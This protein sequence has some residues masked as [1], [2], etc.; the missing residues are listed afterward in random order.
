[1]SEKVAIVV[2]SLG[3]F[4]SGFILAYV[5][6]WRLA[7]AITSI[8][9]CIMVLNFLFLF[10]SSLKYT[11]EGGSLAEEAISTVRTAQAFGTQI[12][13]SGL[14]DLCVAK[15][16]NVEMKSALASDLYSLSSIPPFSFSTTLI[17]RGEG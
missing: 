8:F 16:L 13:L 10:K 6:E 3:A 7:L 5:R 4:I 1:M 17:D 15:S 14:Y 9:P 12:T 2:N 11:A